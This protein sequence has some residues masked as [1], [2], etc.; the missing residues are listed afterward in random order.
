M[1]I[2]YLNNYQIFNSHQSGSKI[3]KRHESH[4]CLPDLGISRVGS[5]N[6]KSLCSKPLPD[7]SNSHFSDIS[8][9]NINID[10]LTE[11]SDY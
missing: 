3:N 9:K 4:Q 5:I 1:P 6:S 8:S 2:N 7:I 10:N 11:K